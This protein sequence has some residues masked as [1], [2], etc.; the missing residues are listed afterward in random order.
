MEDEKYSNPK[1]HAGGSF[2]AQNWNQSEKYAPFI[3]IAR[4][5]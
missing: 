1:M 2:H 4:K 3:K 5:N